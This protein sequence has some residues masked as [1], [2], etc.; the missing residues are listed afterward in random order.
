MNITHCSQPRRGYFTF[1]SY[2]IR[3]IASNT[4]ISLE[5]V[6]WNTHCV[7]GKNQSDLMSPAWGSQGTRDML[8]WLH[9][10]SYIP[11]LHALWFVYFK[12]L[13]IF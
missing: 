2:L 7:F 11:S 4:K 10:V 13:I 9:W 6:S 8:R 5:C 1:M 12:L 3:C